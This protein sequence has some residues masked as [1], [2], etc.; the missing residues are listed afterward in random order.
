M[1]RLDKMVSHMG[2]F[3]RKEVKDMVRQGRITV[4]GAATY[5]AETKVNAGDL[6]CVD[7][8]SL[9]IEEKT[10]LMLH[11]PAGVLTATEDPKQKTVLDLL[12]P[13]YKNRGL[14]PV[15]RLDKDT[16]GLLLLTNDGELNHRL[17]SPKYRIDKVY[18]AVVDGVLEQ[19]D[20]LAFAKGIVLKD[21]TCLPAQLEILAPDRCRVTVQEGK[22]H[23]VKRMLQNRGKEVIY[24]KRRSVGPLALPP[25]LAKGDYRP[26]T[27][28]ELEALR[29][30]CG[31]RER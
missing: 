27:L 19:E 29:V 17:T 14:S 26:L 11:K 22:F 12:P 23:Q 31:M 21:L 5:S 2:G 16:E 13:K 8:V 9:T 20:V 10:C 18:E 7:G 24:L 3:S 1:E 4:N 30:V 28:E 15:G 25:E 6:I